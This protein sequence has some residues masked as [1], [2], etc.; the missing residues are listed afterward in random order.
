MF[1]EV[2]VGSEGADSFNEAPSLH[3]PGSDQR[4][5]VRVTPFRNGWREAA[6]GRAGFVGTARPRASSHSNG[7]Q[8]N[9]QVNLTFFCLFF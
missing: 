5:Q 4:A 3:M 1:K 2:C 9:L 7:E 8:H 6:G